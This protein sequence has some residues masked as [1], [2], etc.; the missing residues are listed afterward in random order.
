MD[1]L[2]ETVGEIVLDVVIELFFHSW[3]SRKHKIKSLYNFQEV[4]K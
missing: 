4:H 1:F 3:E 2:I